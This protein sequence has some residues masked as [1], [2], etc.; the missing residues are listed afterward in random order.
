MKAWGITLLIS[1]GVALALHLLSK[2][3]DCK[4]HE[5]DGQCGMSTF[6]GTIFGYMSA[7]VIIFCVGIYR[8]FFMPDEQV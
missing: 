6:I 2:A 4:P 1:A 5:V 3:G 7:A 8:F